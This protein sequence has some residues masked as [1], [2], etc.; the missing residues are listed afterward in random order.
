[1]ENQAGDGIL[2]EFRLEFWEFWHR[3][4]NK[5]FFFV[6]FIAWLALFQF[7]GNSTL[8]YVPS[9]SIFHW[10]YRSYNPPKPD[11]LTEEEAKALPSDPQGN[12]VPIV[13]LALLWWKRKELL[14]GSLQTWWPALALVCAGLGLHI[15]GYGVQQPRLSV[16]GL[17]TGIYGLM[18]LA[19][20]PEFLRRSFFPYFLFGFCVPL[21]SLAEPITFKLRLLVSWLVEVICHNVLA[22]DVLRK[23]TQLIDP[24]GNYQ[25]EVA[26][27]CSGIRSLIATIGM[28]LVLGFISFTGWWKRLIMVAAGF[29]LAVLGNLA[30]ML[31]IIIAA[32]MGGHEWGQLVHEGGPGGIYSLLPYIPAFFGLLWLEQYLRRRSPTPE[33]TGLKAA[34]SA[35][36]Q[37]VPADAL[38][39]TEAEARRA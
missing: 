14:A 2:E 22:I 15:L 33:Q 3:L 4:P 34:P 39:V 23:G 11:A 31:T 6:L 21:G 35:P 26:A 7:L 30:R 32:E 27:A 17:F 37:S 20:G 13:V 16:M 5:G 24:T 8:G 9:R 29:P 12:I 25:Y 28:G 36:P 1:M 18:G 10:M 19:W 38:S